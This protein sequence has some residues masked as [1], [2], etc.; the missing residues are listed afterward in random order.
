[1]L[2]GGCAAAGGA[3]PKMAPGEHFSGEFVYCQIIA[4][5]RSKKERWRDALVDFR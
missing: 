1:M 4:G 5:L 3:E 2:F